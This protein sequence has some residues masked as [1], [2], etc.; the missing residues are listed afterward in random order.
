MTMKRY[1]IPVIIILVL[2]SGV[3]VGCGKKSEVPASPTPEQIQ[4]KSE[5]PSSE[6]WAVL[7]RWL[8]EL[9]G[10]PPVKNTD[11]LES[12][13]F[14]VSNFWFDKINEALEK[15][16][17]SNIPWSRAA[18]TYSAFSY[19]VLHDAQLRGASSPL[20]FM[21]ADRLLADSV[22]E[23]HDTANELIQMKVLG[24]TFRTFPTDDDARKWFRDLDKD[25]ERL[26]EEAIEKRK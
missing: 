3:V 9:Y 14:L 10:F 16:E 26:M 20:E 15:L 2:A 6:D 12:A 17:Q 23:F 4:P 25:W 1:L 18:P 24:E 7:N 19:Y 8:G 13:A 21:A 22:K 11:Q 5:S